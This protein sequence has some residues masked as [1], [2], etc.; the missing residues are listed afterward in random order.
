MLDEHPS[1]DAP[2]PVG[3][4]DLAVGGMTCASCVTRVEHQSGGRVWA[5]V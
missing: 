3:T 1:H 2:G 5:T 4:V